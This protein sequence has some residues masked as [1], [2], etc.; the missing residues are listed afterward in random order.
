LA[1]EIEKAASTASIDILEEHDI[2]LP[3]CFDENK[4]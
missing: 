1:K 3:D 4:E 2:D